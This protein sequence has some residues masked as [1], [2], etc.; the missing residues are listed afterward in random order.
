[1]K[2]VNILRATFI[3]H[4]IGLWVE[5]AI[6]LSL[7]S[8]MITGLFAELATRGDVTIYLWISDCLHARIS[9]NQ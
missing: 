3:F 7:I 6:F 1:V 9:E 4:S 8:V 2:N 5:K